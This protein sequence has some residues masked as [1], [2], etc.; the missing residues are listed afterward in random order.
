[1]GGSLLRVKIEDF[2]GGAKIRAEVTSSPHNVSDIGPLTQ[3]ADIAEDVPVH[4]DDISNS[5]CPQ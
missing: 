2:R 1:M 5:P 3:A 4:N